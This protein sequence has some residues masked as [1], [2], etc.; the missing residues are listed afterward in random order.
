MSLAN[1]AHFLHVGGS[2]GGV[3]NNDLIGEFIEAAREH[4]GRIAFLYLDGVAHA[5]QMRSLG[6]FGG[7]ERLPAVAFNTKDDRQMPFSER[8]PINRD[9]LL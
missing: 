2:S 8:L 5:D 7:A 1:V 9:T 6:L 3:R 4:Q